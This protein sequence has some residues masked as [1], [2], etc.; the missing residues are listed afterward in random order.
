MEDSNASLQRLRH[1]VKTMNT[2]IGSTKQKAN[3]K[4]AFAGGTEFAMVDGAVI[5]MDGWLFCFMTEQ[6]SNVRKKA[7]LFR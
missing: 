4:M 7:S 1:L 2:A 5:K 3:S 6:A